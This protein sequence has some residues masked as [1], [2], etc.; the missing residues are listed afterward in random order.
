MAPPPPPRSVRFVSDCFVKPPQLP[1]Q[2]D[3]PLHLPPWDLAMLSVHYIQKGLLFPLPPSCLDPGFDRPAFIHSFLGKLKRSLSSALFHFYPLAGRLATLKRPDPPFYTVFV[4][5][6]NSPG[7]RFIHATVDMTVANILSPTY[8]PAV[9]LSLFDHDRAINHD[10]HALSLLS[11]QVTEL[12]DGVFIGLSMNHVVGDGLSFWLF[13]NSWSEIFQAQEKG[14]IDVVQLSHPPVL[15][16]WF[17]ESHPGP[18]SLPYT[19]D[20]SSFLARYEAPELRERV[21]HFSADTIAGL[22]AEANRQCGIPNISS[23]QSLTALVWRCITRA[24]RFPPSQVTGCRMAANNRA[25]LDPPLS[26]EYFGNSITPLRT[27]TTVDELLGGDLGW[28]ARLLH[29]AVAEHSDAKLREWNQEWIKRPQVY[30]LDKTFD[31]Y[32]IMMGSS[33]RFNKYGN[34]FG[35]GKAVA[36]RSGYAHK[37]DGKVS[38]YPGREGGG[39]IDLEICLPPATMA[40]LEADTEFMAAVTVS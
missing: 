17:P 24:R 40:L 6:A 36:L 38:G 29:T 33:P 2:S 19:D 13:F 4:D 20:P 12:A 32:S 15:T 1:P 30:H 7:A 37:F 5:C 8:V 25:R 27:A 31:P 26:P 10:G 34:E 22:K 11:V 9:V 35:L 28:A 14:A 23:F 16:R 3:H 21:F 39:S 18:L